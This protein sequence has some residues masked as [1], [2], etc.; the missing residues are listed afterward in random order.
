MRDKR[1]TVLFTLAMLVLFFAVGISA[2]YRAKK[3]E[4]ISF[5]EHLDDTA[6]TVDGMDYQFRD[7][8]VYLA[9]QEY[10]VEEQAKVYDYEKMHLYWNLHANGIFIRV[11]ARDLAMDMAVHDIIFYNM[12]LEEGYELTKDEIS[13]MENQIMDFWYDLEEGKERLGISEKE[14]E[15]TFLRIALAQKRQYILAEEM[16]VD[17]EEYDV[18]GSMYQEL[19]KEHTCQINETLWKRLNFGNITI[20]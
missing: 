14:A 6:V 2:W 5:L 11:E 4:K 20:H 8:A 9:R 12:A 13:Y 15:E 17:K 1:Q 18:S 19:L 3:I 10:I 7:L 16:G